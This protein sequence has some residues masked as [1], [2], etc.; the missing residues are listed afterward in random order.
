MKKPDSQ[1]RVTYLEYHFSTIPGKTLPLRIVET[2]DPA[3]DWKNGSFDYTYN[4][5]SETTGDLI[6][7]WVRGEPDLSS[8]NTKVY[9]ALELRN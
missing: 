7:H 8:V 1:E 3:E 5:Y 6:A 2:I 9:Q 4:V